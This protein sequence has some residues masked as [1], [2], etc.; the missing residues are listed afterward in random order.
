MVEDKGEPQEIVAKPETLPASAWQAISYMPR[1]FNAE[2]AG[3]LSAIIGFIVSGSEN[4]EAYLN[5]HQGTCTLEEHP[6]RKP[7][8]LIRTPFDV[9]LGISRREIDGQDAFMRQ[10]YKAEGNLGLLMRM[11]Q[12]FSERRV[13]V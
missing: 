13:V 7:D 9:W 12:I 6:A 2:A 3:D 8:L 5:I 4:F 11:K 1:V 10:A